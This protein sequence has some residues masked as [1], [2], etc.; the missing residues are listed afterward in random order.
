MKLQTI[1]SAEGKDEYVLLPVNAYLRLRNEI[2]RV[3][4]IDKP[5]AKAD[6]I[7]F[8][9][10][11]YVNNPIA[12]ARIHAGLSQSELAAR[13]NVTQ[14]YVSKIER[15]EDVS[16]KVILKFNAAFKAA[17]KSASRRKKI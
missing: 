8:D 16:P 15:Q 7:A 2:D 12:L 13:A 6:Y 14:A 10:A 5:D 1:K 9:P 17:P 4:K 11:N 3:L